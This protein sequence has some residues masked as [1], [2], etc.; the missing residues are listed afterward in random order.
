MKLSSALAVAVFVTC[1]LLG[2]LAY[3][4]VTLIADGVMSLSTPC[5]D[6]SALCSERSTETSTR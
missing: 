5:K 6:D 2:Y 3:L 4:S 1:F